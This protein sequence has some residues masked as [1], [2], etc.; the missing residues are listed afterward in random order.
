MIAVIIPFYQRQAGLLRR[1]LLSVYAQAGPQDWHI[2]VVDDGSPIPAKQELRNLPR[3]L[4]QRIDIHQT[5]NIGPGAARNL[6][7]D[8]L[9][10]HATAVAFLD[11]DDDWRQQH[12]ANIRVALA[13][14]ADFYFADHRRQDDSET[15]FTQCGYRLDGP[16]LTDSHS[17]ISWCDRESLFR[18]VILRSPIGT[19]TVAVRRSALGATR[20]RSDFR[21][22]GE[23]SI[24]WLELLR[25]NIRAASC[26]DCE[27]SYGCGVSIFNHRSWGDARAI[28][29]AL[30]QMRTH[31]YVRANFPL[32]ATTINDSEAQFRDLD[33][34]FC[35]AL[36]A[37][38]RRLQWAAAHPVAAYVSDRPQALLQMPRAT[39]QAMR[40]KLQR[41]DA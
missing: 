18:A 7:L 19:S 20:F 31:R 2:H 24:F 41:K 38:G 32:D 5:I 33:L 6:A 35:T 16:W 8:A 27:V 11:S 13:A 30:D 40:H 28:R 15:R 36:I 14:G 25:G 4:I 37:C 26:V 21:N 9:P 34:T 17:H 12:L 29:T 39:I 23:D 1:A 10:G 22:A 3:A